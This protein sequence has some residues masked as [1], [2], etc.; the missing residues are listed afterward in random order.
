MKKFIFVGLVFVGLVIVDLVVLFMFCRPFKPQPAYAPTLTPTDT[1]VPLISTSTPNPVPS[2]ARLMPAVDG[3]DAFYWVDDEDYPPLIYRGADGE[4]AGIFYGIMTE[5][6][7]RLGIPLKV[8]L[9]P[10]S[11]A[12]KILT[13]GAGDG[14]VTVL[15]DKRKPYVISSDPVLLA[16]EQIFANESN[17]RIDEIM[18]IRSLQELRSFRIVETIG[19]GWTDENLQEAEIIWVP[20][21]D[22][23][24]LMLITNRADIYIANGFTG[25]YFIR[26]RV[27]IG[28][29]FSEGYKH[30]ITN[31]YPLNTVAFRLLVKED[32]PYVRI[33]DDF[34]STI[35]QM[36]LDGTIQRIIEGAGLSQPASD[37]DQK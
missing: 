34:N 21:M 10:W 16:A 15:T 37:G 18:A 32:S 4:P 3:I 29:S 27:S 33:I 36:Q 11:R 20:D 13:E 9:Y 30:I 23:A 31:P 14:M 7:R 25:A 6:F 35:H 17:P 26:K 22:N 24:F 28:D 12:Q 5:A 8:E 2:P 1:P 19:S